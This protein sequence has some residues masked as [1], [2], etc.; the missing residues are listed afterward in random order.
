MPAAC[1]SAFVLISVLINCVSSMPA[2]IVGWYAI[3]WRR[4]SGLDVGI[5]GWVHCHHFG[6]Y[7]VQSIVAIGAVALS[8]VYMHVQ[9]SNSPPWQYNRTIVL[10]AHCARRESILHS[11]TACE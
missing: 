1:S 2:L 10:H 3:A 9:R 6:Y 4:A 5:L 8:V 11:K 7:L